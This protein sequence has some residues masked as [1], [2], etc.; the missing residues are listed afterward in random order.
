MSKAT[1]QELR[2]NEQITNGQNAA[3]MNSTVNAQRILAL[4]LSN[5]IYLIFIEQLNIQYWLS[6]Q[7][8][9]WETNIP[10][11]HG[12]KTNIKYTT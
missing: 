10:N 6:S 2:R 7:Y 4:L 8:V 12:I 1:N 3:R 11:D 5:W 9:P